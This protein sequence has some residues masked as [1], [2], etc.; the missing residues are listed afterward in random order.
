MDEEARIAVDLDIRT[1]KYDLARFAFGAWVLAEIRAAGFAIDSLEQFH[2]AVPFSETSQLTKRLIR[3]TESQGFRNIYFPFLREV[4]E[5]IL[6]QEIAPQRYPNLRAHVPDRPDMCIPFHTDSW[7]GH[8][9]DEINV[10]IPLTPAKDS[11]S[12]ALIPFAKSQELVR[13]AQ[14]GNLRLQEMEA[15]FQPHAKPVNVLP[16]DV[17]LFTPLHLHGNSANRTG[18]TRVSIDFRVAVR[19]GTI[20]KKRVGGYFI[21]MPEAA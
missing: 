11:A 4:L 1:E 6:G 21:L 2:E 12:L 18:R 20:N 7:Y 17:V 13:T 19:G 5:P 3:A 8:G 14:Q 10:W 9:Q 16:G 15:L